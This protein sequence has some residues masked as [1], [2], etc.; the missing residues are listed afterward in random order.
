[1]I[2][3]G[4]KIFFMLLLVPIIVSATYSYY[5]YIINEDFY[6]FLNEETV[7][8]ASIM[9]IRSVQD[10]SLFDEEGIQLWNN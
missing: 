5:R 3:K 8:E 6:V 9:D 4:V 2:T 7:P 1:M 10:H